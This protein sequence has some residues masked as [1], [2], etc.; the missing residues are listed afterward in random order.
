MSSPLPSCELQISFL[1]ASPVAGVA[2]AWPRA[3]D[4][5]GLAVRCRLLGAAGPL[6]YP[7]VTIWARRGPAAARSERVELFPDDKSVTYRR[8]KVLL[9]RMRAFDPGPVTNV[10]EYHTN[11]STAL[12]SL[13]ASILIGLHR[14]LLPAQSVIRGG[15]CRSSGKHI[16]QTP[17][18][19]SS[20]STPSARPFPPVTMCRPNGLPLQLENPSGTAP[21][22]DRA[23]DATA[24]SLLSPDATTTSS[25]SERLASS[26]LAAHF[27]R[28]RKYFSG[29]WGSGSATTNADRLPSGMNNRARGA[30]ATH[31]ERLDLP[32]MKL[33]VA[34][35]LQ[36]QRFDADTQVVITIPC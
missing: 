31:R 24:H 9:D 23:A 22:A 5:V 3:A 6:R 17:I 28:R 35:V 18:I 21:Q 20:S 16:S 19:L 30:E 14:G 32:K 29:R 4:S 25:P 8:P 13:Q 27:S 33:Q 34:L 2:A 26:R 10:L 15:A 12:H 1:A 11:I 36:S 7:E